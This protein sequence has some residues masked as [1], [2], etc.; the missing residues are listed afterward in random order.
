MQ[1]TKDDHYCYCSDILV[2]VEPAAALNIIGT[3]ENHRRW[4]SSMK[5]ED[6]PG[7]WLGTS[8]FTGEEYIRIRFDVDHEEH[9]VDYMIGAPEDKNDAL[10]LMTW[11]RVVPGAELGYENNTSIVALYQPRFADQSLEFFL[12]DRFLHASEMYRIKALAEQSAA[13]LPNALPSGE[14][15]AT[16]SD[17]VSASSES[18]FDFISDG[19]EY[20][21]WTWGRSER[22]AIDSD[23]YKCGQ[24]FGGPDLL[25]RLEID[26]GRKTVDYYVGEQADAMLLQQS[27]RVFEGS[28]FGYEQ[29]ISL[30]TFTRWRAAAE[31]NFEWDRAVLSQIIETKM[32][33]AVLERS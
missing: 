19:M 22:T 1:I 8:Y 18:L 26:R 32:S 4:A 29:N 33:K 14:Y 25:V 12:R 10:K 3:G 31:S 23:T 21:K 6:S 17:L 13:V 24:D 5:R 9:Y 7:V 28:L 11:A 27:A 2:T 16:A 30:V 20:G 15:L